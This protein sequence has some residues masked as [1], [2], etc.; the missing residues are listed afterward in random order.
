MLIAEVRLEKELIKF[1]TSCL[2]P[3]ILELRPVRKIEK[4]LEFWDIFG[5]WLGH[6]DS[7]ENKS[8]LLLFY[9]IIF[10]EKILVKF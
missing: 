3:C 4:F 8:R 10:L 2:K 9:D 7:L 6:R 5:H 1:E